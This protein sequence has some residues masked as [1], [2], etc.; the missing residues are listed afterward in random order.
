MS[1]FATFKS[2]N[3]SFIFSLFLMTGCVSLDAQL[4]NYLITQYTV[5]QGLPSNECHHVLQDSLGYIWIATDR[6][7]VKW[8]GYEFRTYGVEDGLTDIA[9]MD[10]ELGFD[11]RLWIFTL[12]D[13]IFYLEQGSDMVT[14]LPN[15]DYILSKLKGTRVGNW[16]VT[17][18][19]LLISSRLEPDILI[20]SPQGEIVEH[21]DE[22]HS[23]G[24]VLFYGVGDQVFYFGENLDKKENKQNNARNEVYTQSLKFNNR[25]FEQNHNLEYRGFSKTKG[26]KYGEEKYI[27]TFRKTN[28]FFENDTL[29]ISSMGNPFIEEVY[30][31]SKN[32]VYV[33][34]LNNKGLYK[35]DSD[36]DFEKNIGECILSD[37][38]ATGIYLDQSQQLWVTTL[39][40]GLFRIQP[41]SVSTK[42][43]NP[44]KSII[45]ND[46]SVIVLEENNQIVDYTRNFRVNRKIIEN[47]EVRSIKFNWV[48][49]RILIASIKSKIL[50]SNLNHLKF[51]KTKSSNKPISLLN[52]LS[53]DSSTLFFTHTLKSFY[54]DSSGD[55]FNYRLNELHSNTRILDAIKWEGKYIISTVNGLHSTTSLDTSIWK[56][57]LKLNIRVNALEAVSD[58]LLIGSNAYGL[59]LYDGEDLLDSLTVSDDLISNSIEQIKVFNDSMAVVST[60][61]GVQFVSVVDGQLIP[62]KSYNISNG[63]PTN[64]VLDIDVNGGLVYVA[65]AKGISV[66]DYTES[67][68]PEIKAI[69]EEVLVNG[70]PTETVSLAHDQRS[71]AIGY[72]ALDYKQNGKIDYR[73]R[74][75]N[76]DWTYT[77]NT[78]VQY[79]YLTPGRYDW[80]VQAKNVDGKWGPSVQYDFEIK[81]PWWATW[82]FNIIGGILILSAAIYAYRR[83]TRELLKDQQISEEMRSLEMKALRA[84]MNPHFVFNSLNSIQ[85]YIVKNDQEGAMTYLSKFA[86]LIRQVLEASNEG[87]ISLY[88]EVRMIENYLSLEK[89]RYRSKFDYEIETVDQ[90]KAMSIYIPPLLVQPY[91]ENAILHGFKGI[92]YMGH[93]S[94]RY[95][96]SD[97]YVEVIIEDNGVGISE[98]GANGSKSLG[99]SITARRLQLINTEDALHVSYD[100]RVQKGT[101]V[102]LRIPIGKRNR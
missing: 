47:I 72:R 26:A 41:S 80:Q 18:N 13:R 44:V 23:D 25:P 77:Q 37:V 102:S 59:Y 91:V 3:R 64:E 87:Y 15:T 36:N 6:G 10:I 68:E 43:S 99:S 45:V 58:H 66:I 14:A 79:P 96:L 27:V 73:Y 95:S 101:L 75:N 21:L 55:F 30:V 7:L 83:H 61:M 39:N 85:N 88:E 65:T 48:K 24:Y 89:M 1:D 35:Y 63:L 81:K 17:K 60:K 82:W 90:S 42:T 56:S 92:D 78:S 50:D 84:Q 11:G 16:G 57:F 100:Q 98:Q 46:K 8:D 52:I 97:S 54:V 19:N 2:M 49:N 53:I 5:D 86:A 20:I 31:D 71:I 38:S 12:S 33:G 93:L 67:L 74:L 94:V 40:K 22:R 32:Q 29:Q 34:Y 4:D 51:L 62:R 9:V 28:Y 69:I 76:N 70:Q